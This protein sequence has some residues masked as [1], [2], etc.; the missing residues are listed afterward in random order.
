MPSYT[1]QTAYDHDHCVN[2]RR[3]P[4]SV[5]LEGV[6]LCDEC[7]NKVMDKKIKKFKEEN[8]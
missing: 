2:S 1:P 3:H 7:F 4:L 5:I 8:E 6:P